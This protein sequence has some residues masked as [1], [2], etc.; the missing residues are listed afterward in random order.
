M[1]HTIAWASNASN[2][3]EVDLTP[4]ADPVIPVT[5]SNH[6]L[7]P[8]SVPLVY[9][10]AASPNLQR[11]RYTT[12]TLQL[13]TTPFIRPI[14]QLANFGIPQRFQN[15]SGDP[16]ML[17][18]TE[19]LSLLVTQTGGAA[20]FVRGV[21]GLMFQPSPAPVGRQWTLRGTATT[22]AVVN[23]WTQLVMT[24]FNQLPTGN[25]AVVGMEAFS[26]TMNSARLIFPNQ[27]YR[28]GC[29]GIVSLTNKADDVFRNGN[30]GTW[31]VFPN[32]VMPLVEVF[33]AAADAAYEIYLDI[34]RV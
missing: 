33:C 26:A 14:N 8:A 5:A 2:T 12:P 17:A 15:L 3:A 23:V 30:L 10:G 29:L 27:L 24:W 7:P 13:V 18:G 6:F 28:P 25:F 34:V 20:E 16:L 4:V 32:F 22:A 1:H 31:G 11:A 21:A 9:I 19:E